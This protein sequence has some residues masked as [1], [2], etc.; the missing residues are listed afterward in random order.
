MS[1]VIDF[2]LIG[3]MVVNII[4]LLMLFKSAK[5][6]LPQ[7]LL[8]LFFSMLLF[9]MA[10]NYADIHDLNVL[11]IIT[12]IFNDVIEI[13][14]GPLIF[15]YIKSLFEDNKTLFKK[16]LFHFSPLL[17][18]LV[19]VALPILISVLDGEFI[20]SYLKFL[21]THSSTLFALF[22]VYLIVYLLL[23]FSLFFKYRKI[24]QLNF[25]TLSESDFG[26][27][28]N[29]LIGSLIVASVDLVISVKDIISETET[30]NYITLILVT[31]L[32]FYLGYYGVKQTKILL[33]DF[34]FQEPNTN[35]KKA[36]TAP[37]ISNNE[38]EFKILE[39][40]LLS[41]MENEKAFL[42]EDLT[43]SKLANQIDTTDKKLS[44]LLNQYM[45]TTFYDF[46]NKY[47]VT[48]VKEMMASKDFNKLT[49]LGIAYESG[50]KS[51]TSFNRIFKKETGLSPSEYKKSL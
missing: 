45:S 33:P 42:E 4:I 11:W 5:K 50:F 47:R 38:G 30:D 18:Y 48:A 35:V 6:E 51:K 8:M 10:H 36:K 27:V 41:I 2:F 31:L 22:M 13:F 40:R 23:S 3:G 17:V 37:I 21:N 19:F 12:F 39:K 20:F 43:L 29:M 34:L 16:N 32:I 1:L 25:S 49:L 7:K 15:I 44:M 9:Y 46:I 24:M 28:R 14:I 26:W